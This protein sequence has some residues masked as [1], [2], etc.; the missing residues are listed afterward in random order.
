MFNLKYN[1][2][3]KFKLKLIIF[4]S[5]VYNIARNIKYILSI[6]KA[7]S[8]VINHFQYEDI[9]LIVKNRTLNNNFDFFNQFENPTF[10]K[11]L[12]A[13]EPT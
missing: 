9:Y 13:S 2:E 8:Y 6:N 12:K 10:K 5:G 3:S 1:E 7:N 4:R 11:S